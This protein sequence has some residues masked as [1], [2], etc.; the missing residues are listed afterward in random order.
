MMRVVPGSLA[1]SSSAAVVMLFAW[2]GLGMAQEQPAPDR[3]IQARNKAVAM[4]VFDEIFNQGKFQV[5]D[6]IY[7][8]DFQN[9]GLHR[10]AD[11]KTDQ[12]AVRAEKKAFPDLRMS[13]Q[14]LV[15]EGDKVAALWTFQGTHTG[16][17]YEGLPPTGT[18]VELRGITI[19]RI[20]DG[21]IS[22]EWSSWSETGAYIRMLAHL[23]WW[24]VFA[25]LFVV[26]LVIAVE[27]LI[28]RMTR[29]VFAYR[30]RIE[31]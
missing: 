30:A 27:R 24:L 26:A 11:L 6:E 29:T 7:A 18:A 2:L 4:R 10:S 28:W 1:K 14:Q 23:K 21:R 16:A 25:G 15:A 22:E 31:S 12:E 5:A 13:V 17:G 19:W 9:H 3:S 20:V 8:P